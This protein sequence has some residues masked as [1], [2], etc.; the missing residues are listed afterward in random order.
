MCRFGG[1]TVVLLGLKCIK[2]FTRR[3]RGDIRDFTHELGVISGDLPRLARIIGL[4]LE[5]KCRLIKN[6]KGWILAKFV[7]VTLL[8]TWVNF[9]CALVENTR[10]FASVTSFPLVLNALKILP[11]VKR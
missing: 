11:G 7:G 4:P 3:E 8:A 2:D 10:K 6:N 5:N 1:V 9:R